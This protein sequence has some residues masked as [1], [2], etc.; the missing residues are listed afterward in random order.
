MENKSR[1]RVAGYSSMP[2][3][4]QNGSHDPS[5]SGSY[6]NVGCGDVTR[7]LALLLPKVPVQNLL[8]NRLNL[9]LNSPFLKMLTSIHFAPS[10]P[11]VA[12]P[13]QGHTQTS[14]SMELRMVY[15]YLS[16]IY[17]SG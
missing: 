7:S 12:D 3:N 13:V 1:M 16:E 2:M 4:G 5:A 10:Q 15:N 6:M 17:V 8:R 14:P 9:G 11:S